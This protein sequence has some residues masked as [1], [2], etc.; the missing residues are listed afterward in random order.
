MPVFGDCL[1]M[2]KEVL[3]AEKE[4]SQSML[5][6]GSGTMGWDAVGANLIERGD[7]AVRSSNSF[8]AGNTRIVWKGR[9]TGTAGPRGIA[10]HDG[11]WLWC[12]LMPAGTLLVHAMGTAHTDQQVVLNCG[13]FADSFADCLET[14]GAKVTQVKA[15]IG[16]IPSDE[17]I[18]QAL[19]SKPKLITITHGTSSPFYPLRSHCTSAAT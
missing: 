18:V 5:I 14:Y 17:Q 9:P 2:L 19:Q 13:Y 15:E 6:A 3:Y 4:G 16:G 8:I 11:P 12:Y 10:W 1:R 7:E